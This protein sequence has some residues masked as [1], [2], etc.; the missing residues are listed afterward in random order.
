MATKEPPSASHE[1][2]KHWTTSKQKSASQPHGPGREDAQPAVWRRQPLLPA[3]ARASPGARTPAGRLVPGAGLR[4]SRPSEVPY[5]DAGPHPRQYG[6][7][8]VWTADV[9]LWTAGTWW[10]RPAEPGLLRSARPAASPRPAAAP[11][12]GPTPGWLRAPLPPAGPP[13]AAPWPARSARDPLFTIPRPPR[14]SSGSASLQPAP[15]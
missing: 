11:V 2:G 13:L 1:P 5:G 6:R 12:H 7:H 8:A 3:A 4:T 9:S 14:S 15:A 10:L